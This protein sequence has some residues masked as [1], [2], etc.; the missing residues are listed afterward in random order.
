MR[1]IIAIVIIL[2]IV[3]LASLYVYKSKKKGEKCIGC[4]HS[5]SCV[6]INKSKCDEN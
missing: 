4:P 2:T 1:D 6:K 3:I 5:C